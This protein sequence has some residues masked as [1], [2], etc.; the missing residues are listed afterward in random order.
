[1]SARNAI[2]TFYAFVLKV[3]VFL[4]G[5]CLLM[6]VC[7]IFLSGVARTAG[8]PLNWTVEVS[9]CLF[10]WGCFLSA[11][12][13]WR[14]EKLM[15][16]DFL[17]NYLPP[18]GRRVVMAANYVI[19]LVFLVYVI[20]FGTRL[21]WVTRARHFTGLPELSYAW[22]TMSFPV[23]AALMLITALLKL[24]AVLSERRSV[25]ESVFD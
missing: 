24:R 10:A 22:V 9:A 13:A 7:L 17:L 14:N 6:M 21:A 15:S 5:S 23:A 16:I 20:V 12:I 8:H 11:D 18:I 4:A 25:A 1:M 2:R 19:I 3:E